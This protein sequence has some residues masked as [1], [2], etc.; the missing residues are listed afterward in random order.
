LQ[1]EFDEIVLI[2]GTI[3]DSENIRF[4]WDEESKTS[5][6][7]FKITIKDSNDE[8]IAHAREQT[9][10]RLTNILSSITGNEINYKLQKIRKIRNGQAFDVISSSVTGVYSKSVGID[11]IDVSKASSLLA[12]DSPLNQELNMQLA[13]AHNGHR[14][15]FNKH[16]LIRI[17]LKQ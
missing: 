12:N 16:F 11:N 5:V 17:F 1:F 13:H 6:K 2:Y 15:F 10:P 14:A 9:A 3:T 7:G 4:V 8:K